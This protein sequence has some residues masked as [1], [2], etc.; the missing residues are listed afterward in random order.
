MICYKVLEFECNKQWPFTRVI[1]WANV[2]ETFLRSKS[3]S[4]AKW[5][6]IARLDEGTTMPVLLADYQG[7]PLVYSQGRVRG[8]WKYRMRT[9]TPDRP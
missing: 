5:G 4:S 1:P 8:G 3:S 7:Q 6:A 2:E 9:I